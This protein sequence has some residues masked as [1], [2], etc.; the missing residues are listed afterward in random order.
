VITSEHEPPS[1][2]LQALESA[3]AL[4]CADGRTAFEFE[5]DDEP[6]AVGSW[7]HGLGPEDFARLVWHGG[8]DTA[9]AGVRLNAPVWYALGFRE[10]LASARAAEACGALD[11]TPAAGPNRLPVRAQTPSRPFWCRPQEDPRAR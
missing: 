2:L 7:C 1:T 6:V 8:A 3:R 11:Q 4:G 9:P 10:G 5:P